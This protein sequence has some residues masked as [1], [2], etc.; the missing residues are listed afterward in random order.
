[1]LGTLQSTKTMLGITSCILGLPTW[2]LTL[3][4]STRALS[5]HGIQKILPPLPWRL[6]FYLNLPL[7]Q[8][9]LILH[10]SV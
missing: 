6:F 2:P 7:I 9:L 8:F 1:M 3:C 10:N 5:F 4:L